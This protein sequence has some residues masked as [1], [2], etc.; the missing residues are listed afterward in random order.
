MSRLGVYLIRLF[1]REALALLG[2]MLG[3]LFL[4]QCLKIF[5]VVVVQN[6]NFFTL[7]GQAALSMPPLAI[8]LAYVCMGIGIVRAL[9][10]LQAS[11]ELHIIHTNR[12]LGA[13]LGGVMVF[14][15]VGALIIL[16]FSNFVEPWSNRR[17]NDW[18]ASV[19]ADIV[20]R[21]LIPHRVTQVVPG[22]TVLISGR[23]GVGNITD[24]FA[25]DRRDPGMRRTYS[26]ATAKVGLGTDGYV[27]ELHDGTLQYFSAAGAFSEISF[28]KYNVGLKKLTE[29]VENRDNLAESTSWDLFNQAQAAGGWSMDVLKRLMQRCSEGLRAIAMVVFIAALTIFPHARRGRARFPLELVPL[30]VAYADKT[31]TGSFGGPLLGY[32]AGPIVVLGLGLLILLLRLRLVP[33]PRLRLALR[34]AA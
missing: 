27:I 15:V 16:L 8:V 21:T 12:Q 32:F 33:L 25:D 31:I 20:G 11:S 3:L 10:A 6:Q 30:I 24:F 34:R 29:Q 13:L 9:G 26:A 19:A 14:A 7:I 17:L 23:E 28:K 2:V 1:S 5:D 4:V 22:V 18:A